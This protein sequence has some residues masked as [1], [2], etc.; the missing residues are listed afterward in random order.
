MKKILAAV[1]ASLVLA[2]HA[3]RAETLKIGFVDVQRAVAEVEEGKSAKAKLK[4]ELDDKRGALESRKGE[5]EKLKADYDKQASVLSDDAKHGREQEMQKKLLEL[6]G[7]YEESQ[8]ELSAKE[9]EAMKGILGKMEGVIHEVS[10]SESFAF[11]L[12]KNS[13]LYAPAASD[14]TNEVIRK[15]NDKFGAGAGSAKN[16]ATPPK[17]KGK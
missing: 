4:K 17:K 1:L 14:L 13:L 5:L 7:M 2:P 16:A 12:D 11:V 6:Q 15:Y 10:D 9:S 3:V 8:Q